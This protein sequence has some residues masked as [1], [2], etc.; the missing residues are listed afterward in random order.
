MT[1]TPDLLYP[2][3]PPPDHVIYIKPLPLSSH[4]HLLPTRR[5]V[6]HGDGESLQVDTLQK[7]VGLTI[8]LQVMRVVVE[9]REEEEE[10]KE[11]ITAFC[12]VDTWHRDHVQ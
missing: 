6:G 5:E 1:P 2:G 8:H 11:G 3:D 7:R 9:E 12:E 4:D 10:V